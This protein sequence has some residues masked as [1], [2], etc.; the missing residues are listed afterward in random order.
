MAVMEDP[1][2]AFQRVGAAVAK[3]NDDISGGAG[4]IGKMTQTQTWGNQLFMEVLGK[5]A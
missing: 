3:V 1:S 4:M 5:Q 2:V